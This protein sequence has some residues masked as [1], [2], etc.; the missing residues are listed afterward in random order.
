MHAQ[1][2]IV[3]QI[4][5]IIK[6]THVHA[7]HMNARAHTHAHAHA[8]THTHIHTHTQGSTY[9]HVGMSPANS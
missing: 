7:S 1:Y 2:A 6:L 8:H 5:P 3:L 9:I 4:I